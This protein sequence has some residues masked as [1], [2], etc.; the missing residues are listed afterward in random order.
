MVE[1][2]SRPPNVIV[3]PTRDEGENGCGC[4]MYLRSHRDDF[5]SV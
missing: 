2:Q 1:V 5:D 4:Q 3:G